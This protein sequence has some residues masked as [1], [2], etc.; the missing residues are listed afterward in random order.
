MECTFCEIVDGSI[1]AREVYRDEVSLAFLDRRP[2][3]LGHCLLIPVV[4]CETIEELPTEL[5]QPFFHN[6]KRLSVAVRKALQA[7][8]TFIGIN[9]K[10]SQSVPHL[11]VHVVPRRS[12]DGLRGFFWPRRKYE[13]E[14]QETQ[15][16]DAIRREFYLT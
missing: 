5:I 9:N 6:A 3:F 14:Q 15:I 4:H 8:G 13:S 1:P 7:D 12:K 2:V 11:H 10:V 16:Q